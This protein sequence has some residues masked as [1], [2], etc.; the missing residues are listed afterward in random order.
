MGRI[1][2]LPLLTP[3][4]GLSF[5]QLLA[6]QGYT[7]DGFAPQDA[8]GTSIARIAD[9]DADGVGDLIVGA[10]QSDFSG[11]NCGSVYVLSG[12][13]G[14]EI[15]RHDGGSKHALGEIVCA[16]GDQNGD[17]LEDYAAASRR[18]NEFAFPS[19]YVRVWSGAD[20]SL[21]HEFSSSTNWD[22]FGESLCG[23]GDVNADGYADLIVGAPDDDFAGP[24]SGSVYV[25]SGIDGSRLH[26]FRGGKTWDRLGAAVSSAGDIDL[27]GYSDF[28]VGVPNKEAGA[29]EAG[30]VEFYSGRTGSFLHRAR[31][32]DRDAYFGSRIVALGDV[33]GDGTTDLG[34]SGLNDGNNIIGYEA[35]AEI[36]SGADGSTIM[37]YEQD[38]HGEGF[39]RALAGVDVNGDGFRELVIGVPFASFVGSSGVNAGTIR[40]FAGPSGRELSRTIGSQASGLFGSGICAMDHDFSGDGK[41]DFVV[42]S[43]AGGPTR[44]GSIKVVFSPVSATLTVPPLIA[45]QVA[46]VDLHGAVPLRSYSVQA[47]LTGLGR[48][49]ASPGLAVD[50]SAPLLPLGV[51]NTDAA[52]S[53]SMSSSV[54]A[55]AAGVRVW[56][57][58]WSD[59][60]G[61]LNYSSVG[62]QLIQ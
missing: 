31:G 60:T 21:L 32:R 42:S 50:L 18:D 52:G 54:P 9:L 5:T 56:I 55:A 48:T 23:A 45:G 6:A 49:E 34:V 3:V 4:V 24:G 44:Q 11:Q 57:Q 40:I 38:T 58:A 13:D 14:S 15:R 30:S 47:S 28:A 46:S 29:R 25:Y 43:A 17:G 39:A 19:G 22:H 36:I 41:P 33:D 51:M 12:I 1:P 2:L 53:A 35:Y 8:F 16:V 20:G 37:S 59:A 10:P 26:T 62:T 7:I 61:P 27:D